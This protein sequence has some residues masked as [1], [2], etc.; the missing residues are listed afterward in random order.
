MFP[1][2]IED[3]SSE[4]LEEFIKVFKGIE[5]IYGKDISLLSTFL[6]EGNRSE[7]LSQKDRM[8]ILRFVLKKRGNKHSLDQTIFEFKTINT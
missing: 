6:E 8:K 7:G 2:N 4:E 3:F 5:G 1:E